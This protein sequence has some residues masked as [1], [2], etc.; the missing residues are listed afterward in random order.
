MFWCCWA[1]RPL[2]SY[3]LKKKINKKVSLQSSST[4]NVWSWEVT[5]VGYNSDIHPL[6]FLVNAY[7]LLISSASVVNFFTATSVLE[8]C[9]GECHF[10]SFLLPRKKQ[11]FLEGNTPIFSS[12]W[13]CTGL[14][15]P[16]HSPLSSALPGCQSDLLTLLSFLHL[17]TQEE[18]IINHSRPFDDLSSFLPMFLPFVPQLIS[19]LHSFPGN[20]FSFL[21]SWFFSLTTLSSS[22]S[23]CF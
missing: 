14:I 11:S 18:D 13:W 2:V 6:Y 15:Y 5:H 1:N 8:R 23:L 9:S 17:I 4:K 19:P 12:P 21:N 3:N 7:C 22:L 10:R 20:N 16:P